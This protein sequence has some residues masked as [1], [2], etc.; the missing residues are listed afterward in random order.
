MR[1]WPVAETCTWQHSTQR[2]RYPSH[3][4]DSNPQSQQTSGCR[5]TP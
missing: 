2:D 3:W 5:P 4:Q 1:D